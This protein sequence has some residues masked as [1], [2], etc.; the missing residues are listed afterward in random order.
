M[1]QYQVSFVDAIKRCLVL[2][3][4]NFSGRS[5]RSEFWWFY[6]LQFLITGGIF[7]ISWIGKDHSFFTNL[8]SILLL[9]PSLG[10][11]VRRLHDIG[12]GGGWIFINCIPVVGNIIYII[13]MCRPS[14]PFTNRFGAVPNLV[15]RY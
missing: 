12:K 7:G 9:L 10:V 2:N 11:A 3:Y 8:V 15:E 1:N 14:E 13:W 6:L 4:C 5:S